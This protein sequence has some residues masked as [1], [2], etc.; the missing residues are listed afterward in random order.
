MAGLNEK[1]RHAVVLRYFYDK[2]T[3]EIGD[4]LGG[5]EGAARLRLHRAMEKLRRFFL[6]RGI[7]STTT[8]IAGALSAHSVQIAP[9]TLMARISAAAIANG[10]AT[11]STLTLVKGALNVMAWTKAKSAALA[12]ILIFLTTGVSV[13]V[14]RA[15]HLARVAGYPSL[16]GAWEGVM[17]LESAGVAPGDS[18]ASSHVVLKLAKTTQGYTAATDWIEMGRKDVPMGR[19]VYEYPSLRIER[20]PNDIWNLKVNGDA[21]QMVLDHSRHFIQPAPVLLL[22]T[23]T[24]DP[25]P[26]RLEESDF[27]PRP[28]SEL[29]GYWKGVFVEETNAIPVNIKIA[30][31]SA[32]VYRLESDSPQFGSY[33]EPGTLSYQR[34]E[35]KFTDAPGHGLFQGSL[36]SNATEIIGSWTTHGETAPAFLKRADYAAEHALDASRDYTF[37]SQSDLQGHWKGAWVVTI[38]QSK[39]SIRMALD[40]A[41]M[42]DGSYYTTGSRIDILGNGG[43]V[44]ASDFQF[45]Q[46]SV[47]IEWKWMGWAYEGSLQ[48]G[49]LRGRWMQGGGAFPLVF[50][51][52]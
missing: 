4:A 46:S 44:P 27:S 23:A 18:A 10:A 43:P 19:V 35:I 31:V 1:D 22:R 33:G 17:L 47:R 30:E 29:Q 51:R 25:V 6:K 12:V 40:I 42:P 26:G 14:L 2:S 16:Q 13:A 3:K 38:G 11:T 34:P 5:S 36:R 32:G 15:I 37:R 39:A 28:D 52:A 7:D 9:I 50:E 24:P 20:G 48:N 8:A 21:T 45:D 49:K 41:R